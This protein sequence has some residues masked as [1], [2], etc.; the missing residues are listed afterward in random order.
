VAVVGAIIRSVVAISM[1]GSVIR[2]IAVAVP[3]VSI[4]DV[5]RRTNILSMC[6][7]QNARLSGR[8]PG[9]GDH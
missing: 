5:L 7:R 9:W 4:T 3:A 1:V 8:W 2:T 6:Q